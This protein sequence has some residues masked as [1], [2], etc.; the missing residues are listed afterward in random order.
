MSGR[1]QQVSNPAA[2]ERRLWFLIP[3]DLNTPTGGYRYDRRMIQGLRDLDWRVEHRALG[4][5]FPLP[6]Q[7]EREQARGVLAGIPDGETVVVDGLAYGVLPDLAE[8][9]GR[10]LRLIALVHHPL[11]METGLDPTRS[12]VLRRSEDRA[13]AQARGIIVTS[14]PTA[15]LLWGQGIA[16]DRIRV[17]VPG[18]DR[19]PAAIGA[20]D[21]GPRLLF[22]ATLTPRKGHDLLLRA[23]KDLASLPWQ[24]H[25]VGSLGRDRRW[26]T[27]MRRLTRDL[28]LDSR[29]TFTGALDDASLVEEYRQADLFV[30]P[31]RFEGYGMVAAEAL[32]HGLPIVA[33]RTGAL[34]DLVPPEVGVLVPPED[35]KA[36]GGVLERLLA[37]EGLRR[38]LAAGS[39]V[40]GMRLPTWSQAART[41]AAA[42]QGIHPFE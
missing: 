36:L 24:L 25:C 19:A 22:V 16:P 40:A 12:R 28:G 8:L 27:Q 41:F 21:P 35:P 6:S 11:W 33:T 17:V 10:R 26:S 42:C 15:R 1:A 3:G 34:P 2:P 29:V 30:F 5:G 38:R 14:G 4:D 32:A 20:R 39:R 13:L 23:L 18:V 9:H 7:A 31:S 37:D